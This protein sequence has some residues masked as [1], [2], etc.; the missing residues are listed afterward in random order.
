MMPP[1]FLAL[2]LASVCTGRCQ[3]QGFGVRTGFYTDVDEPYHIGIVRPVRARQTTFYLNSQLRVACSPRTR[4][5]MT[6]NAEL[7]LRLH[8]RSRA[9]V[10]A[11]AGWACSTATRGRATATPTSGSNLLFGVGLKGNVIPYVQ[12]KVIVSE[13]QHVRARVRPS[14]LTSLDV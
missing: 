11:G 4:T 1:S 12:G 2:L 9:F 5:Y 13:R 14:L 10:W 3:G 6:F 8:T 7:P